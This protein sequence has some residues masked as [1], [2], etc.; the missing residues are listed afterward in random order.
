[1]REQNTVRG[2]F[3]LQGTDERLRRAGFADR[4]RVNPDERLCGMFPVVTEAL[5]NAAELCRLAA[6]AP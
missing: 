6:R 5:W 4:H 1:M 3:L 2:I